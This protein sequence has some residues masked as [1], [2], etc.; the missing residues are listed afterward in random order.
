MKTLDVQ[1]RLEYARAAVAVLRT[2][3]ITKV[4]ITY[5]DFA[6]AIG[7]MS[8]RERWQAWHQQQ[9]RDI[10]NL[11]A[12]TER[13]AG[14]K[15]DIEPLQFNRIVTAKKGQPGSGFYKTSKIITESQRTSN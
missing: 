11:T 12:A 4:T 2:L 1:A 8:D 13:K 5:R 14:R 6:R 7:L 10:L 3:Q 15:V 9:V